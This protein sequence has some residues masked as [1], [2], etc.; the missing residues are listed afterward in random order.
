MLQCLCLEDTQAT[1]TPILTSQT[2]T[3]CLSTS[4]RLGSGWNG[5]LL[6]GELFIFST[7]LCRLLVVAT[8]EAVGIGHLVVG[9]T[10]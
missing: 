6:A 1:F 2:K 4:S 3:I 9:T 10:W 7:I 5:N 8:E